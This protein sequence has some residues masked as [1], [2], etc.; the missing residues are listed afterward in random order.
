MGETQDSAQLQKAGLPDFIGW[1]SK[2][3]VGNTKEWVWMTEADAEA[4][5]VSTHAEQSEEVSALVQAPI[6]FDEEGLLQYLSSHGSDVSQFGKNNAKS[7]KEF[8]AELIRGEAT[9][10]QGPDGK[11]VRI[12][13]VVLM[14]IKKSDTGEVLV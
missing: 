11:L 8:S 12:V 2:D 14:I 13:D 3:A 1:K 10:M 4:K 6:G 9:L 5:K 7:I